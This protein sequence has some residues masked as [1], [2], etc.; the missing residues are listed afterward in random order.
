MNAL[1]AMVLGL[2]ALGTGVALLKLGKKE[3]G[4]EQRLLDKR[5]RF[6]GYWRFREI[7]LLLSGIF[8]IIVGSLVV[9]VNF[10]S[11]L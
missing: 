6:S 4:L 9:I 2:L 1:T 5:R 8:L 10:T 7:N 3:V 11:L